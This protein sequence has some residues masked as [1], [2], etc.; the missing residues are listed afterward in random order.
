VVW[1]FITGRL[2]GPRSRFGNQTRLSP[3]HIALYLYGTLFLALSIVL[4]VRLNEW[5]ENEEGH[6]YYTKLVT[7]PSASHPKADKIYVGFCS[8]W[9]LLCLVLAV[10]GDTRHVK[11]VLV[12]ALA[13]YPLHIYFMTVVRTAN[14]NKLEGPE[15]ENDWKF[16]QTIAILLLFLTLKDVVRGLKI[17]LRQ[18]KAHP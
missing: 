9:L 17:W 12:L 5:D 3:R 1:A 15:S 14:T 10:I 7:A 11:T 4:G 16:G 2:K 13:Q 18:V 8:A 6:C